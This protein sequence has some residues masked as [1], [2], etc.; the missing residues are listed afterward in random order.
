[1]SVQPVSRQEQQPDFF[2]ESFEDFSHVGADVG[3]SVAQVAVGWEVEHVG[4][5]GWLVEHSSVFS[6]F[7]EQHP[8]L[9]SI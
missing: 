1:M 9:S 4:F 3:F 6:L 8:D 7:D 5:A 2:G